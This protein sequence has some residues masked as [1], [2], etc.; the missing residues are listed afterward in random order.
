[1]WESNTGEVLVD[2]GPVTLYIVPM[3]FS[4]YIFDLDGTLV[5]TRRDITAAANEMLSRFGLPAKE[6]D[7]VV[8]Y[9][10]DGL[11]KLVERLLGV[12]GYDRDEALAVYREAYNRRM[13]DTTRP[14]RGIPELLPSLSP[15]KMAVLTNKPRKPAIAILEHLGLIDFFSLVIGGD[16]LETRKP[17]PEGVMR[18][19]EELA[20]EA[21][22][23]VLIG[24]SK[25][26]VIT[27]KRAGISS[28]YVTYGFT[29]P[30][31]VREYD[32]DYIVDSPVEV[33]GLE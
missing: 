18:I 30:A 33:A 17:D 6:M 12:D 32:P 29:D 21:G 8:G 13:L 15:A 31:S 7:E 27:A 3:K 14:Y 28:V 24:D 22:D 10:G 16:S 20:A 1:M 23:S 2:F 25:N 4:L 11:A 5:D 19:L 9:V 26:D